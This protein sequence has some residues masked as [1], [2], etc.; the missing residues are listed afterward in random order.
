MKSGPDRFPTWIQGIGC[1]EYVRQSENDGGPKYV[2]GV[3]VYR[4]R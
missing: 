3:D 2:T 1:L 4:Y